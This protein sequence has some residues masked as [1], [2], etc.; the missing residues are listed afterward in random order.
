MKRKY[1][2]KRL[3]ELAAFYALWALDKKGLN[4]FERLLHEGCQLCETELQGFREV[5]S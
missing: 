1:S 3:Q 4:E 2:V 5:V